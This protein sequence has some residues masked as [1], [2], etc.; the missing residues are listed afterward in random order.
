MLG[1]VAA[2]GEERRE[3]EIRHMGTGCNIAGMPHEAVPSRGVK[4]QVP[5]ISVRAC[6][7]KTIG[8]GKAHSRPLRFR[9]K[10]MAQT[11]RLFHGSSHHRLAGAKMR[12]SR[13]PNPDWEDPAV[14]AAVGALVSLVLAIERT[15]SSPKATGYRASIRRHGRALADKGGSEMMQ[16]VLEQVAQLSPVRADAR[17]AIIVSAWSNLP[18]R[19]P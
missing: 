11:L 10:T 16:A 12:L 13:A 17:R 15:P 4:Q 2:G 5:H 1:P 7:D 6:L 14:D 18:A 3:T 9:H 8:F 19:S